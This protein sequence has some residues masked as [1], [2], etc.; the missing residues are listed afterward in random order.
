MPKNRR[1]RKSAPVNPGQGRDFVILT[2]LPRDQ[3]RWVV[4]ILHR[5]TS[6]TPAHFVGAASKTNDH[7][8][9]Y[10]PATLTELRKMLSA[11]VSGKAG[12][13]TFP[14]RRIIVLYVP[15][16]DSPRLIDALGLACYM[17]RLVPQIG[18]PWHVEGI[19]WRHDNSLVKEAV[20]KSL[21]EAYRFTNALKNE[22]TDKRISALT[23]PARNFYFPSDETTI[24][25][26]YRDLLRDNSRLDEMRNI[27]MPT[28][29]TRDELPQ[30]AFKSSQQAD[31]FY[32][33]QR[34]RIFPPDNHGFSRYTGNQGGAESDA[35]RSAKLI[36]EQRYRFGVAVRDGNQHYDVQYAMPQQLQQEVMYCAADGEV[37]ITGSH[38]NVGVND[39][40][41]AP[42]G[43][44]E[45][46]PPK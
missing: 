15:S 30:Q 4:G 21:N 14:P 16:I 3:V 31:R 38:A 1:R 18:Y 8:D 27:L 29:F 13:W 11:C 5:D 28:R 40:I 20:Y 6:T 32:Q 10:G 26:T 2:G 17:Q 39:V 43:K 37:L 23:L 9:L 42:D 12:E 33:D 46:R 19:S 22:I 35:W 45:A 41:W 7:S 36:L 44:K 25:Y 34:G 24:E